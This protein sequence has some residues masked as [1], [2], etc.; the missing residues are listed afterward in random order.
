VRLESVKY[1]QKERHYRIVYSMSDE[2][3]PCD[4]EVFKLVRQGQWQEMELPY[5]HRIEPAATIRIL[6]NYIIG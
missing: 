1:E 6:P 2:Q 3:Y 5:F 4:M